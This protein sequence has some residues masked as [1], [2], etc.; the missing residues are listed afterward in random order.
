MAARTLGVVLV[1]IILVV[2]IFGYIGVYQEGSEQSKELEDYQVWEKRYMLDNPEY[3]NLRILIDIDEK[4]LY[5][6]DG[7]KLIKKYLVATGASST[8]TP[9]GRWKVISKARWGGGFGSRWIGIDVPWGI[10]GI[11]GTNKPSSIGYNA[12]HGCVRMYNRDV[13]DLYTYV[14][15]GTPVMIYG[16]IYGPFRNGARNL[17]PGDK[18]MDVVEVQ[19][20]LRLLG[21]YNGSIDGVYG[22]VMENAL[23]KF[24]QDNGL[25][26]NR[27]IYYDTYKALGIIMMD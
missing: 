5:L 7:N 13:E 17:R 21:Y 24:Q 12:S 20:R 2:M 1:V 11:H 22:P 10:Y 15:Y 9:V 6:L 3:E 16:G 19:R 23:Y 14:K 25:A 27:I 8:P 18:G 4:T 26:K